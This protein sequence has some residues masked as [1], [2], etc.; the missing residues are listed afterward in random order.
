MIHNACPC[1]PLTSSCPRARFASGIYSLTI[2]IYDSQMGS[3]YPSTGSG[4]AGTML[5]KEQ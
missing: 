3:R 4:H 5:R 2:N 1:I